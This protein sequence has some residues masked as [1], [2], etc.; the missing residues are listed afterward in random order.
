MEE[1]AVPTKLV[2]LTLGAPGQ[3]P[4][5]VSYTTN[6]TVLPNGNFSSSLST[7]GLAAGSYEVYARAC[8]GL[9]NCAYASQGVTLP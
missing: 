5:A 6:P 1:Y 7:S 3:D 4:A 8:Y 9:D 2:S